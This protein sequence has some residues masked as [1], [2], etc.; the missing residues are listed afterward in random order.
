MEKLNVF[1]ERMKLFIRNGYSKTAKELLERKDFGLVQNFVYFL[2]DQMNS[3]ENE[4]SMNIKQILT[5]CTW[6]ISGGNEPGQYLQDLKNKS[7]PKVCS[8]LWNDGYYFYRC[9]DC[10]MSPSSSICF[11]CFKAGNHKDHDFI[12]EQSVYGGCCDCGNSHAWKPS[13]FCPNHCGYENNAQSIDLPENSQLIVRAVIRALLSRLIDFLKRTK[14]EQLEPYISSIVDWIRYLGSYSESL[15]SLVRQE[16]LT[17]DSL[18]QSYPMDLILSSSLNLSSE[19]LDDVLFLFLDLLQEPTFKQTFIRSY[20]NLYPILIQHTI[21]TKGEVNIVYKISPQLFSIPSLT[22]PLVKEDLLFDTMIQSLFN[23]FNELSASNPTSGLPFLDC[24]RELI[25]NHSYYAFTN[26]LNTLLNCPEISQYLLYERLDLLKKFFYL[27]LYLQ[28]INP[29]IRQ[30]DKHVEYDPEEWKF[31]FSIEVELS[32][33]VIA[34][35]EGYTSISPSTQKEKEI[36]FE[37]TRNLLHIIWG[38]LFHWVSSQKIPIANRKNYKTFVFQVSKGPISFH[39]PLNRTLSRILHEAIV[40]YPEVSLKDLLGLT[41]E[42]SPI[43]LIEHPLQIQ[44]LL[45][46]VRADMWIRNGYSMLH[47]ASIYRSSYFSEAY[48]MDI[49]MLQCGIILLNPVN[50]FEILFERFELSQIFFPNAKIT[51]E[52]TILIEEF[53]RLLIVL[54]FERNQI[55][56]SLEEIVRR[57]LIHQLAVEDLTHSK[58]TNELNIHLLEY[59][60][61]NSVLQ[62]VSN[63]VAPSSSGRPGIYQLKPECWKEFDPFFSHYE[64]ISL[65]KAMERFNAQKAKIHPRIVLPKTFPALAGVSQLLQVPNLHYCYYTVLSLAY[66]NLALLEATLRPCFH[67]LLMTLQN[68]GQNSLLEFVR[69][70]HASSP[71]ETKTTLSILIHMYQNSK[72]SEHFDYLIPILRELSRDKENK[73]KITKHLPDF[74]QTIEDSSSPLSNDMEQ[75]RKAAKARQ[76]AI[77]AKF[78]KQQNNFLEESHEGSK[79]KEIQD[80]NDYETVSTGALCALCRSEAPPSEGRVLGLISLLQPSRLLVIAKNE[81]VAHGTRELSESDSKEPKQPSFSLIDSNSN[82]TSQHD[83]KEEM[84]TE[85]IPPKE[86]FHPLF[87]NLDEEASI[88]VQTCGHCMHDDCFL[89]FCQSF[90]FYQHFQFGI[91]NFINHSVGE[92]LCPICRR[93]SNALIPILSFQ[94]TSLIPASP[95]SNQKDFKT[96]IQTLPQSNSLKHLI[97]EQTTSIHLSEMLNNVVITIKSLISWERGNLVDCVIEGIASIEILSRHPKFLEQ[98][99]NSMQE[100]IKHFQSFIRCSEIQLKNYSIVRRRVDIDLLLES[101]CFRKQVIGDNR[102]PHLFSVDLFGLFIRLIFHFGGDFNFF[103]RLIFSALIIQ[104]SISLGQN[105]SKIITDLNEKTV[106]GSNYHLIYSLIQQYSSGEKRLHF[107]HVNV[108]ISSIKPLCQSFL[109]RAVLFKRILNSE[110]DM[111]LHGSNF[112][113]LMTELQLPTLDCL[114][115]PEIIEL[116]K[117][118][119][120]AFPLGEKLKL[121]RLS[122]LYPTSLI[123]LPSTFQDL[124]LKFVG[125]KCLECG[126][127]P[128]TGAICLICGKLCCFHSSCC[129]LNEKG[130]CFRHSQQ[131]SGIFLVLKT[132]YVVLLRQERRSYWKSIYLD[133]HGEEDPNLRRGKTLYLSEQRYEELQRLWLTQGFD[134]DSKILNNSIRDAISM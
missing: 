112:D 41:E 121:P 17:Y 24:N 129:M 85:E 126:G 2:F 60:Q 75:K 46:Q 49:F 35:V 109:R 12:F 19:V 10:E 84:D 26:D 5:W 4:N 6:I 99:K 96:W 14:Q 1:Q 89:S 86:T 82:S 7:K 71:K 104:A 8:K 34:L 123:Q 25:T 98:N 124:V 92:F 88:H 122:S 70:K 107:P 111:N 16:F 81:D 40:K 100:Q 57:E 78:A 44:V 27:L 119:I 105:T 106:E 117:L 61:F 52:M 103:L 94:D 32:R 108:A 125:M 130:E 76:A 56:Y 128:K 54:I 38:I 97:Q 80:T 66:S 74:F 50:F 132:T 3:S 127:I 110:F 115:S 77:L 64:P 120:S 33:S 43:F 72:F 23:L 39:I 93:L 102:S 113:S 9:R 20:V 87:T 62:K 15:I 11:E 131:C 83:S 95:N 18:Q 51:K 101:L 36:L 29:N 31:S 13:G 79:M 28:G 91:R 55:G 37:K 133:S 68:Q 58:L 42:H 67:L 21:K 69:I 53:F 90:Q 116:S 114:F 63:Y 22:F 118:W 65:Q 45:S 48:H 30:I 59:K 47:Q 73:R 134:Y